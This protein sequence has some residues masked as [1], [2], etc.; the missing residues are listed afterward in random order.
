MDNEHRKHV[1]VYLNFKELTSLMEN[2]EVTIT[3]TDGYE[4]S[5]RL[6]HPIKAGT[7]KI[8]MINKN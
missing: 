8:K 6:C 3:R 1:N 7:L 5:V 4:I 2:G